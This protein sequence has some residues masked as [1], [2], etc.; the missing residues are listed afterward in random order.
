MDE[1]SKLLD[2]FDHHVPDDLQ[3]SR[4]HEVREAFK[5]CATAV[6]RLAPP[7]ADRTAALRKL[8]ESM[9]TTN[10]AIILEPKG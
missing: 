10:K 7:S 4:I 9:M 6:C 1:L 8:H 5:V 2:T 3:K